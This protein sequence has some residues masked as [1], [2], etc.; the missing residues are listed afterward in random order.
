MREELLRHLLRHP[1]RGATT[2]DSL[3]LQSQEISSNRLSRRATACGKQITH[4]VALRLPAFGTCF[5]GLK[6][7]AI[8]CRRSAT[9]ACSDHHCTLLTTAKKPQKK[10]Q[11]LWSIKY[12]KHCIFLKSKRLYYPWRKKNFTPITTQ[13]MKS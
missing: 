7:K 3:G 2:C 4:A 8:A 1:S 13:Q 9:A 12:F 11:N 10:P 6:P 5:L